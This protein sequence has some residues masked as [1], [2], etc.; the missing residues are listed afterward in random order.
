M[1]DAPSEPAEHTRRAAAQHASAAARPFPVA[2]K[3]FISLDRREQAF[4]TYVAPDRYR[5]L[6]RI[7]ADAGPLIARGAGLSYVAASFGADSLSVS[8]RRFNRLLDFDAAL[9]TVDVEAG[10]TLGELGGFLAAH[11]FMLPVQ[12]G[13]PSI[14][15]GGCIAAN[16][17]GKNQWREGL[18]C[19][20]LE[21]LRL[22]HPAHGLL[23]CSRRE[24]AAAFRLTCGGLGLSGLIVSAR[25]R[26]A[27]LPGALA[28]VT[29]HKFGTLHEAY[30]IAQDVTPNADAVLI[31]ADFSQG[32]NFGSGFVAATQFGGGGKLVGWDGGIT[33]DWSQ[34]AFPFSVFTGRTTGAIN[35]VYA[36]TQARAR[37]QTLQQ[38]LFPS[39]GREFYYRAHGEAGFHEFQC[40]LPEFAVDS[41]LREIVD[42]VR[43]TQLVVALATMKLF[44]GPGAQI[45]F[46]GDGIVLTLDVSA[47]PKHAVALGQL[48]AIV[49]A[50]GGAINAMK[51]SRLSAK[52]L[53]QS[54]SGAEAFADALRAYDPKRLFRSAL[55]QR[56]G[57]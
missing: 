37:R 40:L 19:D 25:I 32:R 45:D 47:H 18:F 15:I 27:P 14:T 3:R 39:V 5:Q 33:L 46:T 57:L 20:G 48:E 36:T 53:R 4:C 2:H 55:S 10:A 28:A 12:P 41:A 8:M 54:F 21:D 9:R 49:A 44:R 56:L 30:R 26:V 38:V 13:H 34:S 23:R 6:E 35:R 16:A 52:G 31:W 17:H 11:G 29:H 50:H 51:Y 1:T 22:L 42:A 7:G 43:N 24:N